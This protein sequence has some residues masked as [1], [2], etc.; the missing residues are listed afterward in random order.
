VHPAEAVVRSRRADGGAAGD[1]VMEGARD[2]DA[3]VVA[4]H[5][6]GGGVRVWVLVRGALDEVVLAREWEYPFVTRGL[7]CAGGSFFWGGEGTKGRLSRRWCRML[8]RRGRG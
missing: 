4:C 5:V 6:G 7:S 1:G 8:R 2:G 3:V